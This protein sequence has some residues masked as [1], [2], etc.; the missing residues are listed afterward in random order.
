MRILCSAWLAISL[1]LIAGPSAL[2]AQD[3]SMLARYDSLALL[4][5]FRR[6]PCPSPVPAGWTA[7][8]P[9]NASGV[10]CSLVV[11][12]ARGASEAMQA[13]R[14]TDMNPNNVLCVALTPATL[15]PGFGPLW[16]VDFY[17]DSLRGAEVHVDPSGSTITVRMI[18]NLDAPITRGCKPARPR[19]NDGNRRSQVRAAV[20]SLLPLPG[21]ATPST[22]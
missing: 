4:M 16:R 2:I 5:L 21:P 3:S 7:G 1:V 12:A 6:H 11:A 17:T 20:T 14:R 8:D 22:E 10:R 15:S 19:P 18:V 9:S 13:N